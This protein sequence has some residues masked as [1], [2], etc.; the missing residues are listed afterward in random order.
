MS[1]ELKPCPFCCEIDSLR[2]WDDIEAA[3]KFA[4][5]DWIQVVCDVL[6][7]GCGCSG[8]WEKD[9]QSAIKAWNTRAGESDE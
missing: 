6:N 4:N 2:L 8:R 1:E 3:Y 5:G 9:K 7:H